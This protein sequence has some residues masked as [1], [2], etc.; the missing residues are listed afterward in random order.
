MMNR[1]RRQVP[2]L[3]GV[4]V[5]LAS[6]FCIHAGD[7][8]ANEFRDRV[9]PILL[10]HCIACHRP[11]NRKGNYDLSRGD[12][13][14]KGRRGSV[15][16]PGKPEESK[17][18][19]MLTGEETPTMPKDAARLVADDIAII[20]RWIRGGAALGSV[21]ASTDIRTL[22]ARSPEKAVVRQGRVAPITALTFSPDGKSLIVGA[23]GCLILVDASKFVQSRVVD[24][25]FTA[26]SFVYADGGKTLVVA[27]GVP[28]RSGVVELRDP[29]RLN[30][31][32]RLMMASDV[33]HG[34]V[35]HA[36]GG[37][38]AVGMER[39]VR[40][41]EKPTTTP[42]LLEPVSDACLDAAFAINGKSL[43][44]A[45]RDRTVKIWDLKA[46]EASGGFSG[47]REAVYAVLPLPGN[48]MA[49]S[50]SAD[51]SVRLWNM[52]SG[53]EKAANASFGKPLTRLTMDSAGKTVFVG[54]ADGILA[55]LNPGNLKVARKFSGLN[56]WLFTM[57]LS[58]DGKK[59]AA[60]GWTGD[61]VVW[62]AD[63]GKKIAGITC[64]R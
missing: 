58:P 18:H 60:A 14:R 46:K 44:V 49:V 54:G 11:E 48:E 59:L 5:F 63:T 38:A 53:K 61:I 41:W 21:D 8:N 4:V 22:V 45:G 43:L 34:V 56:D 13:L 6:P 15:V 26:H 25:G 3:A 47:H 37:M 7:V 2:T 57:A 42:T 36:T 32:R 24:I 33:V 29:V 12:R 31:G 16:I 52:T 35:W 55:A 39:A 62:D 23:D 10:K 40:F 9:V 19:L 30:L 28:G 27:G 50:A 17:F 64:M 1:R 20:E 51:G